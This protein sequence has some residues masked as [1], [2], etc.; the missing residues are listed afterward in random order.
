MLQQSTELLT[1]PRRPVQISVALRDS[2]VGGN[3]LLDIG[4]RFVSLHMRECDQ[5]VDT[6]TLIL[7]N[8]DLRLFD[9]PRF[10][11]GQVLEFSWGSGGRIGP[12]WQM[13]IDEPEGWRVVKLA[14]KA[15]I[16]TQ[17]DHTPPPPRLRRWQGMTYS[18]IAMQVAMDAGISPVAVIVDPTKT[19]LG[20]VVQAGQESLA[21]MLARMAREV[22]FV[23]Y[24]DAT[25]VFHFHRRRLD[26]PPTRNYSWGFE[27]Q[28]SH[29]GGDV[30]NDPMYRVN[31]TR[32]APGAIKVCG[33]N[34]TTGKRF[35]VKASNATT[36]RKSLGARVEIEDPET[37][38]PGIYGRRARLEVVPSTA[39][40]EEE[41]RERVDGQW[42]HRSTGRQQLS[43]HAEGD[44][45][46]T[47]GQVIGFYCNSKV[48][49][50]PWYVAELITNIIDG[51]STQTFTCI[52]DGSKKV[53]LEFP[54]PGV[55]VGGEWQSLNYGTGENQ[56]VAA[57]PAAT[58][59]L[60]PSGLAD[61][62]DQVC[63][64]DTYKTISFAGEGPDGRPQ[65]Q[66]I[67]R[68]DSEAR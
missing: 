31:E 24:V 1:V 3:G 44:P 38:P 29:A 45:N 18:M 52:R 9:D 30:L 57:K 43:F 49:S 16:I 12:S 8:S 6:A 55:D 26:Q 46:V 14:G 23:F 5:K 50:G 36:D 27:V 4:D 7:R 20:S 32:Q 66:Q 58:P 34:H 56:P 59:F 17:I 25:G 53:P 39:A 35:E 41:A 28:G 63:R 64:K 68:R 37:D 11:A 2:P 15:R 33:Y 65:T 54:I 21:R 47:K 61:M 40:T 62:N 51:R 42:F 60:M 67:Y 13:T 19:I 10:A 48:I 22:G